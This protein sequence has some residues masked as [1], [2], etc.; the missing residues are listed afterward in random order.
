[1]HSGRSP[2]I[3]NFPQHHCLM[4]ESADSYRTLAHA[5]R[6]RVALIADRAF[7]QRDPAA[8]LAQLQAVSGKIAAATAHLPPHT[9]PRLTHYLE[10]CSYT[11]ALAFLEDLPA[12][13]SPRQQPLP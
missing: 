10:R 4:T 2:G 1:M 12:E 7:Y 5:L 3:R 9:D 11:K 13:T 8:H 6:E